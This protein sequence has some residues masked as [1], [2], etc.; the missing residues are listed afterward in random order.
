MKDQSR[1]LNKLENELAVLKDKMQI[2][3]SVAK[4]GF[5]EYNYKNKRILL[6]DEAAEI[7]GL[8]KRK[9]LSVI[10]LVKE[11]FDASKVNQ[12]K[13]ELERVIQGKKDVDFYFTFTRPSD[14]NK[15][16]VKVVATT[17]INKEKAKLD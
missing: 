4:L 5:W 16:T 12:I 6:S 8:N 7:T 2:A 15:V 3:I 11:L 10:E 9:K 14:Y 17:I 13:K 1:I